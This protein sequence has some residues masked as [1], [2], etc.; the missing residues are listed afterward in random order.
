MSVFLVG[1]GLLFGLPIRSVGIWQLVCR[2]G[3]VVFAFWLGLVLRL[4]VCVFDWFVFA[5]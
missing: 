4:L 2:S 3:A 1:F 5:D